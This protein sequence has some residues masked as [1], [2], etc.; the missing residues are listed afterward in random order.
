MAYIHWCKVKTGTINYSCC[1]LKIW[2][3]WGEENERLE[4][5]PLSRYFVRAYFLGFIYYSYNRNEE[6]N[7]SIDFNLSSFQRIIY[8][9][10]SLFDIITFIST[11]RELKIPLI[12]K[13]QIVSISAISVCSLR[14]MKYSSLCRIENTLILREFLFSCVTKIK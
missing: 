8:L 12:D 2:K 11:Q 4:A 14:S 10:F 3:C 7:W 6:Y 1:I 9:L 5:V 13:F